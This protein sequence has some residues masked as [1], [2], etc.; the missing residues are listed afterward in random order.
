MEFEVTTRD[1]EGN[2]EKLHYDIP[3]SSKMKGML[4]VQRKH[5]D[6]LLV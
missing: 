3:E 5:K 4:F 6:H 2:E 1:I